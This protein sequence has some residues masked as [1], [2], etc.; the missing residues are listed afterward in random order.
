MCG[1]TT[2][3]LVVARCR[4]PDTR[5]TWHE[6]PS[7]HPALE[8]PSSRYVLSFSLSLSLCAGGVAVTWVSTCGDWGGDKRELW[9]SIFGFSYMEATS[10]IFLW[11]LSFYTSQGWECEKWGWVGGGDYMVTRVCHAHTWNP[12]IPT[13]GPRPFLCTRKI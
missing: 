12:K 5:C 4:I 9:G 7:R 6:C 11:R 10:W 3:V 13:P 2:A 8:R 1:D